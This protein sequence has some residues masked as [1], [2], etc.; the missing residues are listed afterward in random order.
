MQIVWLKIYDEKKC[1]KF[2]NEKCFKFMM[3]KMLK[4]FDE[5]K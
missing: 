3:K 5:Q 1:L 4:F 2:M